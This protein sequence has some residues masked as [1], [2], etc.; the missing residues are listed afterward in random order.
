ML[1]KKI[2]AVFLTMVILCLSCM[3]NAFMM[4]PDVSN[5]KQDNKTYSTVTIREPEDIKQYLETQGKAY[6][7]NIVEIVVIDEED[8]AETDVP[9]IMPYY[10]GNDYF[11]KNIQKSEITDRNTILSSDNWPAGTVKYTISEK[12]SDTVKVSC[13]VSYEIVCA[14]A[15]FTYTTSRSFSKAWSS[16]YSYPTNI[17]VYPRYLKHTYDLW[18][19]DIWYDDYVGK[20]EAW[21]AI[22]I[23]VAVYKR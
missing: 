2:V 20:C 10:F 17:K 6:D 22:G 12:V 16:K 1:V 13:G 14:E 19:D 3:V 4:S 23:E 21:K 15:G 7:S 5:S 9:T 18:E 8:Q 11:A